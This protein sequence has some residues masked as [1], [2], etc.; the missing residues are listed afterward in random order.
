[1]GSL[2]PA[3]LSYAVVTAI[4]F[5]PAIACAFMGGKEEPMWGIA[6]LVS[7]A[8]GFAYLPMALLSTAMLDSISAVNPVLV[9]PAILKVP[10]AYLT[11]L[12]VL[13]ILTAIKGG[14]EFALESVI[15]I[16][17]LPGA[18]A[19]VFAFYFLTVDARLLGVLYHA[20]RERIGWFSS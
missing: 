8:L 10:G 9:I 6:L 20:N 14:I 2:V 18:V 16:P 12:L 5:L 11:T 7:V 17:I 4:C 19:S 1:M 15:P 13:S 3:M